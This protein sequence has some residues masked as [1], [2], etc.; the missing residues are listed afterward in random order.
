MRPLTTFVVTGMI[1]Y[2]LFLYRLHG[3]FPTPAQKPAQGA[4]SP[5]QPFD[6]YAGVL[7]QG[8]VTPALYQDPAALLGQSTGG[9][10]AS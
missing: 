5:P 9:I 1:L 4:G 10:L 3:G 6:P 2:G 8:S 7:G